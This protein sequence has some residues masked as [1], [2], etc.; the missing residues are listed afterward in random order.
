MSM[1][2]SYV[3]GTQCKCLRCGHEWTVR[4]PEKPRLCPNCNS[5]YWDLPKRNGRK[6]EEVVQKVAVEIPILKPAPKPKK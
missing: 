4:R 5:P 1:E 6:P 3:A 2:N